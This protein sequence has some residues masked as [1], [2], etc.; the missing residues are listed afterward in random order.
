MRA[1]KM[2]F[3][4]LKGVFFIFEE[5]EDASKNMITQKIVPA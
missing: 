1:P 2:G 3:S 4:P 5:P